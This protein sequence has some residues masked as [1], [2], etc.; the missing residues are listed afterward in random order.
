MPWLGKNV[1]AAFDKMVCWPSSLMSLQERRLFF[2]E[3]S[4]IGLTGGIL[5][6][7]LLLFSF[8]C[9]QDEA[10]YQPAVAKLIERAS[11]LKHAQQMDQAISRL[12]AAADLTPQAFEVQY[13]LGVLYSETNQWAKAVEHLKKAVAISPNQPNGLY[14]LGFAYES[15]GDSFSALDSKLSESKEKSSNPAANSEHAA[16]QQLEAY[17]NALSTYQ[18]FLKVAPSTDPGRKEVEEQLNLLQDRIRTGINAPSE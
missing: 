17:Q 1:S 11:E 15:L 10:V 5:L 3:S 12:E 13:N 9:A 18:L 4:R 16:T 6:S 7:L 14:T 8:G 2:N